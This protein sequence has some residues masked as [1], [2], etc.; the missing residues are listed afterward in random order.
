MV[1]AIRGLTVPENVNLLIGLRKEKAKAIRT[2]A[3]WSVEKKMSIG[4]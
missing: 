4:K 2:G 1:N 3:I